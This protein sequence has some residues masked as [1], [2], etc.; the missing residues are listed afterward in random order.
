VAPGRYDYAF[1]QAQIWSRRGE[2][3]SARTAIGPLMS[4]LYPPGVRDSARSLMSYIVNAE[5]RQ[6][7]GGKDDVATSLPPR[8]RSPFPSPASICRARR[9]TAGRDS[10]PTTAWSRRARLAPKARSIASIARPVAGPR[11]IWRKP[12]LLV[13]W[14]AGWTR[15]ISFYLSDLDG[16]VKCGALAQPMPVYITWRDGA[17]TAAE[18][19]VIAVEFLPN[20]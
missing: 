8:V 4:G 14:S 17:Q 9:T 10:S 1:I 16:G 19:P 13:L 15:W 3:A 5:N 7:T 11:F 12:A 2:F 20:K 6:R 18:K